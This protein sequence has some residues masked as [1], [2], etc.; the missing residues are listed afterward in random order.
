MKRLSALG[1]SLLLLA[2]QTLAQ[3]QLAAPAPPEAPACCARCSCPDR[4]CCVGESSPL[5]SQ[6]LPAV[7]TSPSAF[8]L[9]PIIPSASLAWVLPSAEAEVS[10]VAS[11]SPPAAARVPL[12]QRDCALLI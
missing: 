10:S 2:M 7:P 8:Q 1:L 12:F 9:Q 3:V 5:D 11:V 4:R 6:S